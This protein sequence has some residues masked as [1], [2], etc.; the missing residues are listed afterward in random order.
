MS[1]I[2]PVI[3]CGGSGTRLWPLSR[4]LYPKQ[5]MELGT[6]T[7]F[8]RTLKR[9]KALGDQLGTFF[10]VCNA[11]HRFFVAGIMQELDI[12]GAIILEPEAKN[13]APA[14]ALAA[15]AA[16]DAYKNNAVE[17]LLLILPS[18][19]DIE[20]IEHFLQAVQSACLGAE[21]DKIMTF[22]ITPTRPET[23]FGYIKHNKILTLENNDTSNQSTQLPIYTVEKFVE[24]PQLT[25]AEE[26]LKSGAYTWNSGMF[27]VKPSVYLTELE[28]YSPQIK[29]CCQQA[30]SKH[31]QDTDFIRIDKELF[32]QTP[33]QSIDY[34]IME[35]T[36]LAC[37]LPI[38]LKWSDL[39][40]WQSFYET[41]P[42]DDNK[43]AIIGDVVIDNVTGCYLHS[44]QRLIAASGIK[45]LA[46][47][48]TADAVLV[49]DLKQSQ[50]VKTL[51][52]KLKAAKRN[53]IFAH[54]KVY[55][56]W[57]HYS[58][59]AVA[60]RFQVK[61]IVV[62]PQA[63]L[64]LQLHHH[65]AEHWVVVRGTAKIIL[66]DKELLLCENQSTYIPVGVKHSLQNP[67]MIPLEIIEIQSG[68]YLGEDDIVRFEDI[69]GRNK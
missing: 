9:V 12:K 2:C 14:I 48:D 54:T 51:Y 39:G 55:R 34:A 17:P 23:G 59:L 41:S 65:R 37:V 64:S 28:K 25:K 5:F 26:F 69:Y 6:D 27:L 68:A 7:L 15:L 33:A 62:N 19:H 18:D 47:I 63:C 20:P 11:E 45:D 1:I 42:H 49:I 38:A 3:L 60:E 44:S 52:N 31:T 43:N 61:S 30:W 32:S 46:V 58:V 8:A 67:G 10:I 35:H 13:T 4:E 24:K 16:K 57:G 50:E 56:P 36:K 40:S 66:D 22:G 21:A 29:T 53:E